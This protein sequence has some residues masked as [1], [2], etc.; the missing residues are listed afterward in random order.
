M[1]SPEKWGKFEFFQLDVSLR[2]ERKSLHER[3]R[4]AIHGRDRGRMDALLG[5]AG[6][7]ARNQRHMLTR[8]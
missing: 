5:L 2:P 3:G 6:A 1:N 7:E 8:L 4:A